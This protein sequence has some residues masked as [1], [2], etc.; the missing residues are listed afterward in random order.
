MIGYK[1]YDG[2]K[3]KEEDILNKHFHLDGEIKFHKRGYH[4]CER[5]EDTLRYSGGINN[6]N[7]IIAKIEANNIIDEGSDEYY[8]FFD[9]YATSDLYVDK[10]L[11]RKEIIEYFLNENNEDRVKRFIESYKL[12][13]VEIELF[14]LKYI[15]NVLLTKIIEYYQENKKDVF[16]ADRKIKRGKIYENKKQFKKE[17]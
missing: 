8:G 16:H 3:I 5:I 12:N 7:I 10:I 17:L 1:S 11:T 14:K 15:D 13:E 4:F 2:N 6:P 9:M